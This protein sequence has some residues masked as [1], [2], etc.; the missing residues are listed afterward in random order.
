MSVTVQEQ[1]YTR[2]VAHRVMACE[3]RDA[4]QEHR[5]DDDTSGFAPSYVITRTGAK[6]NRL[7]IVGVLIECE[8]IGQDGNDLWRARVADPTGI[9]TVYAGQY[10]P[11]AAEQLSQLQVPSFV[12]VV[13]KART[14]EPE[15]GS[16]FVSVRPESVTVVDEQMRDEWI[17]EAADQALERISARMTLAKQDSF[18]ATMLIK[19]DISPVIAEGAVMA[20][21]KYG[22]VNLRPYAEKVLETVDALATGREMP[23]PQPPAARDEMGAAPTAPGGTAKGQFTPS[24][25]DTAPPA[26]EALEKLLIDA[27]EGLLESDPDGAAWDEV[28]DKGTAAGHDEDEVEEVLNDLMDK[29]IVYE[30]VLGKLKMT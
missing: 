12:A 3:L 22:D 8:N 4:D 10:Q 11:E 9:F 27:V 6:I 23:I 16:V 25:Q 29:G 14:Y 13:G 20:R 21:E 5:A 7:F 19:A 17:L 1:P 15:P 24:Q 2:E 30:P 18:D 28:V 26:N